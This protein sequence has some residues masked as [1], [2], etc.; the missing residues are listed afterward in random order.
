M[1]MS[2]PAGLAGVGSGRERQRQRRRWPRPRSHR[3]RPLRHPRFPRR[4]R[5]PRFRLRRC[6][7]IRC[8][9]RLR[10]PAHLRCREQHRCRRAHRCLPR[11]RDGGPTPAIDREARRATRRVH[12]FS[13]GL[14][15]PIRRFAP[16]VS[17]RRPSRWCG[18][19]STAVTSPSPCSTRSPCGLG[20]GRRRSRACRAGWRAACRQPP[21]R[22]IRG[23]CCMD[24]C[25]CR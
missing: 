17:T 1:A 14:P 24:R 18:S 7:P 16:P 11:R 2:T 10:C 4:H 21:S 9:D 8:L 20:R 23:R 13:S 3:C 5:R 25:G 15:A 6:L 19:G 12:R 22:G